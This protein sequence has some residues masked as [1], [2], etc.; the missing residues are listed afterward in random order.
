V[1]CCAELGAFLVD[2]DA[3]ADVDYEGDEDADPNR[4]IV[5]VDADSCP[6]AINPTPELGPLSVSIQKGE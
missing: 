5:G 6:V 2:L 1:G 4:G 3:D